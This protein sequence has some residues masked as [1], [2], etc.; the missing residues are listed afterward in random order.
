MFIEIKGNNDI[1]IKY[2]D[3]NSDLI[4]NT[5]YIN[6]DLIVSVSFQ[7]ETDTYF[8]E[9]PEVTRKA[10][11][12]GTA[13]IDIDYTISFDKEGMGEYNRIKRIIEEQTIK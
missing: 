8:D 11:Y 9:R 7:E 5:F 13:T 6:L 3:M 1:Y 10:I 2:G 12:F 4:K